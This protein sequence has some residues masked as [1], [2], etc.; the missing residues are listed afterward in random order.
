MDVVFTRCAGLDVHTK[1]LTACRRV[2]D[3]TGHAGEGS[4]ALRTLAPMTRDGLRL[5]DGLTEAR[6]THVARASTGESWQPVSHLLE[7]T[8]TVFL[9]PATQGKNVPGRPTDQADARC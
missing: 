9:V 4:A 2:P 1:R 7:D 3:P 8:W 5:A 6:M